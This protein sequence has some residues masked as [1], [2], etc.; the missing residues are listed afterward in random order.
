MDISVTISTKVNG[1]YGKRDR[2]EYPRFRGK[3][4]WFI[5]VKDESLGIQYFES[6]CY[7]IRGSKAGKPYTKAEHCG[8]TLS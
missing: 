8:Y 4:E 5:N 1:K 2:D 6:G 7:L 3:V